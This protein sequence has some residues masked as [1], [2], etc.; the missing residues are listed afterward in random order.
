LPSTVIPKRRIALLLSTTID[1]TGTIC[2]SSSGFLDP[3]YQAARLADRLRALGIPTQA[4]R[5]AALID[6]AAKL[7]AAVLAD[8][9]D[10]HPTTAVH[11]MR[12]AG[13]DWSRYA[14]DIARTR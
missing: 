3:P 4:A 10:L 14:A 5:R 1:G 6:L 8:L 11:W 12:E 13:G 2:R 7:P 9:L